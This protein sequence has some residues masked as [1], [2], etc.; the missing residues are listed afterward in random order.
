M[1]TFERFRQINIE[2]CQS[3][4]GFNHDIEDWSLSDWMTAL[5]GEVGE[6]ANVLKKLNRCRDNINGNDQTEVELQE[7]FER[8]IGDV[9]IYLDLL[10]TRAGFKLE[11][12][13]RESWNAKSKKIGYTIQI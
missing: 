12:A 13:I 7:Q 9:G 6:A 5:V 8:E 10:A 1:L 4:E 2:R 3:P 11:D